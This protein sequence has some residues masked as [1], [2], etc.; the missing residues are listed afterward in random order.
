MASASSV[1][2]YTAKDS[3][4]GDLTE[5]VAIPSTLGTLTEQVACCPCL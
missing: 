2:S 5:Q 3:L 1:D 4:D